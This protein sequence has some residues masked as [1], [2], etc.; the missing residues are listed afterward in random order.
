MKDLK[1]SNAL[2]VIWCFCDESQCKV[3]NDKALDS[4]YMNG[5]TPHTLITGKPT[6]ISYIC[7][8]GWYYW[9]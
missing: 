9:Y 1:A 4:Y 3:I 6:N 8:F 7:E 2:L 5:H